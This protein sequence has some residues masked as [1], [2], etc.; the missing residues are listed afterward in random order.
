MDL[1]RCAAARRGCRSDPWV[2]RRPSP[3]GENP[4]G[5]LTFRGKT[6]DPE[7]ADLI[8]PTFFLVKGTKRAG[9]N[10]TMGSS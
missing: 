3:A 8:S 5:V 4:G 2:L 7:S 1:D 10:Y 9:H 6:D